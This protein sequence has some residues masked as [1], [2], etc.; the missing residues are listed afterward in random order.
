MVFA[1]SLFLLVVIVYYVHH[2]NPCQHKDI[3]KLCG[4]CRRAVKK[5]KLKLWKVHAL[6]Q[7]KQLDEKQKFL[8]SLWFLLQRR[9]SI[10]IHYITQFMYKSV[11]LLSGYMNSYKYCS[12]AAENPHVFSERLQSSSVHVMFPEGFRIKFILW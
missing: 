2:K 3:L 11:A 1:K 9:L 10:N 5:S 6:Q 4:E 8:Y 7:M 12:F